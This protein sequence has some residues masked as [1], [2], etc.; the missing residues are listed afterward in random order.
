MDSITKMMYDFFADLWKL[1]K[2]YATLPH[3][4]QEWEKLIEEADEVYNKHKGD[5]DSPE[6]WFFKQLVVDWME[7]IHQREIKR[8]N[9]AK[10]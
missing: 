10:Q 9:E 3:T 1:I 7:Y 6:S 4:D 2:K 8:I 5:A